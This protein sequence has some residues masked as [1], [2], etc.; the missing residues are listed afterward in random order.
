MASKYWGRVCKRAWKH[1]IQAVGLDTWQRVVTKT[2]IALIA[3][4][5][6]AYFGGSS[7]AISKLWVGLATFGAFC[8]VFIGLYLWNFVLVPVKL[9]TEA[10]ERCS[11]LQSQI[12]EIK[13]AKPTLSCSINRTAGFTNPDGNVWEIIIA[14]VTNTGD[15]H[16]VFGI[17]VIAEYDGRSHDARLFAP[18]EF[19]ATFPATGNT[20]RS[21]EVLPQNENL[22]LKGGMPV[23]QGG[24]T[25]G[26]LLCEF[27]EL[28]KEAM[29]E[30][31]SVTVSVIDVLKNE[32]SATVK[33][34]GSRRMDL[35][36]VYPGMRVTT[37]VG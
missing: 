8:F 5:I 32:S 36:Q 16:S 24:M 6:I 33:T 11:E 26:F 37:K 30:G 31:F 27:P 35:L 29:N 7:A 25:Q 20:P 13:R 18:K 28:D 2:L 15:Y 21:I 12:L 17:R 22:G 1:T 3:I 4:V 19:T 34:G 10:S 9:D 23:P 14:T